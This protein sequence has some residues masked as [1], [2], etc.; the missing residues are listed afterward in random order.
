MAC[1]IPGPGSGETA[2][3]GDPDP[4]S[5]VGGTQQMKRVFPLLLLFSGVVSLVT[6]T[7]AISAEPVRTVPSRPSRYLVLDSRIIDSVDGVR[8]QVGTVLKHPANPFFGRDKPWEINLDNLYPNVAYDNKAKL[9]KCWYLAWGS[10]HFDGLCY[11]QS[12][13]GV[14][15]HKPELGLV[16]FKGSRKNNLVIGNGGHGRGVSL[17]HHEQDPAR[18]FKMFFWKINNTTWTMASRFSADGIH[19]TSPSVSTRTPRGDT[20]NNAFW[21]PTL[22]KYVGITR[23]WRDGERMVER[24]ES[25]DHLRWSQPATVFRGSKQRQLYSMPVF[26]HAG[27]YIG[28]ATILQY[29]QGSRVQTELAWSPDTVH[30]H[31]VQPG[32]PLIPCSTRKGDYDWGMTYPAV[33]PIINDREIRLYYGGGPDPHLEKY[34]SSLCLA[35]LRPDGFAGYSPIEKTRPGTVTT[36]PVTGPADRLRISADAKAGSVQVEL[37]SRDGRTLARSHSISGDVTDRKVSWQDDFHPETLGDTPLVLRFL[38]KNATLYSF[39]FPSADDPPAMR[40]LTTPSGTRFGLFG[41]KPKRPSPTF[42]VFATS[43]E[44]MA[45]SLIYTTTGRQLA[46]HGWLYVTLDPPCHGRDRKPNEPSALSGWAHRVKTGQ[47][48]VKP[49]TE[50]CRDVLD[51]LVSNRYTDPKQVAAGGTSRGGFCALHLAAAEPRV[52]T[53]V[54]VSPVTD[55]RALREFQGVTAEQARP[56]DASSLATK[57]AGRYISISI[58]NSDQRV[59]TDS[60]MATV[61]D[62]VQA[63]VKAS[64]TAPVPI[65]LII[66]PSLGHSA[67]DNAYGLAAEFVLKHSR[68]GRQPKLDD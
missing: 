4:A 42:F 63:A 48:P 43:V 1:L 44:D 35:T 2:H 64:P 45:K 30:W 57:L 59:S 31:H 14:K 47:D 24:M 56:Y 17:D 39:S 34:D 60:C 27:I 6:A 21:A 23:S 29:D 67:I 10:G 18:R 54:C 32:T 40:V 28:L 49:F 22:G 52:R 9:Y 25:P 58:G 36:K 20:H 65:E 13:D 38:L 53:V 41:T 8:L 62:F 11:A 68:P 51:W 33:A 5:S 50:R 61:R 3:P 66:R 19:W 12:T 16:E 7:P 26:H 15:W 55:L 46:K 37:V